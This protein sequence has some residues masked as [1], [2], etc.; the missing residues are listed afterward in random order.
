MTCP[1]CGDDLKALYFGVSSAVGVECVVC[2]TRWAS[3]RV[4]KLADDLREH[5]HRQMQSLVRHM[6]F[7]VSCVQMEDRAD[8]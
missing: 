7:D 1:K 2:K 8:V 5:M 6:E 4:Q 3:P